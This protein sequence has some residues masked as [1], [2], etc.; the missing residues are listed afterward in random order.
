MRAFSAV[1]DLLPSL[2]LPA[3]YGH[4]ING[5]FTEPAAGGYFDNISPINGQPFIQAAR[6]TSADIARAV[7]AA[8]T[9]YDKT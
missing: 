8:Q 6:G 3:K 5:E 9:A 7:Q 2:D 4:F 1:S